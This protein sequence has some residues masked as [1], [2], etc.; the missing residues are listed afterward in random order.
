MV[1]P[2]VGGAGRGVS[3]GWGWRAQV[4]GEGLVQGGEVAGVQG[5]GEGLLWIGMEKS[6]T[7]DYRDFELGT[8]RFRIL[9]KRLELLPIVPQKSG[10]HRIF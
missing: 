9:V 5:D 8:D 6:L 4:D 3:Q 10:Y 2:L 7:G 1:E